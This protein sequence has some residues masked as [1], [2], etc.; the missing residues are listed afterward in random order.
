M[1]DSRGAETPLILLTPCL[2]TGADAGVS[3]IDQPL[4]ASLRVDHARQAAIGKPIFARIAH[5]DGDDIV[6]AVE[7]AHRPLEA[8]I[9]EIADDDHYRAPRAD[10]LEIARR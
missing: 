1:I 8:L 4:H 9:N 6:A 3:K 2:G 10:V 7:P 5:R